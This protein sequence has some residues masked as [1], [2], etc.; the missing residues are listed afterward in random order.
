MAYAFYPKWQD[1]VVFSPEGPQP[2]LLEQNEQFRVVLAGLEPG[3]MLPVHPEA[4][5]V[6]HILEGKGWMTAGEERIEIQAGSIV[7]LGDGTARGLEA[8]TR[9]AFLAIRME[10]PG[11]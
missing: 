6:F 10:T 4:A 2:K 7:I 5:S 11:K 1:Q 9:L 3:Q 8:T